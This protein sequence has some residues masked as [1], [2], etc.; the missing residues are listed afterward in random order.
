VSSDSCFFFTRQ[1]L[2]WPHI[3]TRA[4]RFGFVFCN[5]PVSVN[6]YAETEIACQ[7]KA[8]SWKPKTQPQSKAN[9]RDFNNDFS[10]WIV[11]FNRGKI[12]LQ[13]VVT[14]PVPSHRKIKWTIYRPR[15]VR[16]W[17]NSTLVCP[18]MVYLWGELR[19]TNNFRYIKSPRI[20]IY[21][22]WDTPISWYAFLLR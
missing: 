1:A 11:Q 6:F 15:R 12:S 9:E 2:F 8:E 4:A 13:N 21:V 5:P 19:G 7:P 17:S 14:K 16:K 10:E 22:S 3:F 20:C 18:Q